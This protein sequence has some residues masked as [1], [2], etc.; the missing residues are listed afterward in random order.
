MSFRS[1]STLFLIEQL[2]VIA[3][4]AICATACVRIVTNAYFYAVDSRD[5]S[6][7][8]F[9]AE[10]AADSFKA[11]AGDIIETAT[12]LGGFTINHSGTAA[13]VVYYNDIWQVSGESDAHYTLRLTSG[14]SGDVPSR[15]ITGELTVTRGY[16]VELVSFPVAVTTADS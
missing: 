16:G 7:A 11:S 9:A 1:K 10:S 4:F 2:I 13:L 12:L 14:Q 8:L 15:L 6:N 3:V 5:I